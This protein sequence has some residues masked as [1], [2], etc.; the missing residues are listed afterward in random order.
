[1]VRIVKPH[2]MANRCVCGSMRGTGVGAVLL[3]G[4][5]GVAGTMTNDAPSP[6][7]RGMCGGSLGSSISSKLEKLRVQSKKRPENIKFSI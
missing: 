1:M 2:T 4:S 5:Q 6:M 3:S 7:G